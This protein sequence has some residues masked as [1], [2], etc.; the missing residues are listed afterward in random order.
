M[1]A[2]E[3]RRPVRD[4]DSRQRDSTT[5]YGDMAQRRVGVHIT[6]GLPLLEQTTVPFLKLY[7]FLAFFLSRNGFQDLSW[8]SE[9]Y[10]WKFVRPYVRTCVLLSTFS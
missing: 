7:T 6:R 1:S 4:P 8:K 3:W 10:S 9:A 2:H 5:T